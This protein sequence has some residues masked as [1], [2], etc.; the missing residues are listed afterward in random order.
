MK[1]KDM[2]EVARF[3]ERVLLKN[4]NPKKIKADIKEFRKDFQK[5]H[6][7]FKKGYRGYDYHKLI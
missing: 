7:C 1:E 6:Y 3:F 4:E 2:D 5:I